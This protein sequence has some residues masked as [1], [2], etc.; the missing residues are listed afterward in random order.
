MWRT[1]GLGQV[2]LGDVATV[3]RVF[4][5]I[6]GSAG[7]TDVVFDGIRE[8][9]PGCGLAWWRDMPGELLD[10]RFDR[11]LSGLAEGLAW[12]GPIA[13]YRAAACGNAAGFSGSSWIDR[14]EPLPLAEGPITMTFAWHP[15]IDE[16]YPLSGERVVLEQLDGDFRVAVRAGRLVAEAGR[17]GSAR[18]M[19]VTDTDLLDP[20]D[21]DIHGVDVVLDWSAGTLCL[22]RTG[23]PIGCATATCTLAPPSTRGIRIG[24][25]ADGTMGWRGAI[26]ELR[27][28]RGDHGPRSSGAT[29]RC[30]IDRGCMAFGQLEVR[31]IGSRACVAPAACSSIVTCPGRA[32]DESFDCGGASA[33]CVTRNGCFDAVADCSTD[34]CTY[35]ASCADD[36]AL[37]CP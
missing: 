1:F 36:L 6:A 14:E 27:V 18:A 35:A 24:A 16:S 3:R 11:P 13:I 31:D 21:R 28:Q 4:E 10:E 26:D 7:E 23:H 32:M 8:H 29:G 2:D 20:T 19:Q 33:V 5:V 12:T 22:S 37:T 15:P 34:A 30:H 9:G 25:A 17:C